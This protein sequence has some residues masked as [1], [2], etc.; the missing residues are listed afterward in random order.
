MRF[1][2]CRFLFAKEAVC[3]ISRVAKLFAFLPYWIMF[4]VGK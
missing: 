3:G 4:A 1:F 2:Y